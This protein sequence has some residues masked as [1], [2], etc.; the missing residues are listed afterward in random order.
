MTESTYTFAK[1][2]QVH[3]NCRFEELRRVACVGTLAAVTPWSHMKNSPTCKSKQ[4]IMS[5]L[6]IYTVISYWWNLWQILDI[7]RLSC[8]T[9]ETGIIYSSWGRRHWKFLKMSKRLI[10]SQINKAGACN[11][12]KYHLCCCVN[13]EE[14]LSV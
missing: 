1:M 3:L 14:C 4:L 7:L 11:T 8:E 12:S 2:L 6:L 9:K 10:M 5:F 13:F